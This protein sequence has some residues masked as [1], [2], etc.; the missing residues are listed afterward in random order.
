MPTFEPVQS[1]AENISDSDLEKLAWEIRRLSDA[2]KK[3]LKDLVFPDPSSS[4]VDKIW[5]VVVCAFVLVFL[6]S[7]VSLIVKPTDPIMT[8][9]MT[10]AAFLAGLLSPSP[11]QKKP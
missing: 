7:F 1:G 3:A 11:V 9:F 6:G 8:I 10:T 5:M 4:V 2:E